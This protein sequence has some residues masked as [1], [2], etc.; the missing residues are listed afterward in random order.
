MTA[1]QS[2]L[3]GKLFDLLEKLAVEIFGE[4]RSSEVM[5]LATAIACVHRQT[6][7]AC[8]HAPKL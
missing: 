5:R 7:E 8:K 6:V 4:C 1:E 2:K 3:S